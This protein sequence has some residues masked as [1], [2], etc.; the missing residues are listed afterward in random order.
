[1]KHLDDGRLQS[2][3]DRDRS[4]IT[5]QEAMEVEDHVAGCRACAARLAELEETSE[6]AR[7]LLAVAAP[8]REP[9][10]DFDDVV[11]RSRRG[12]P[13]GTGGR[14]W[15]AAGW[16]ASLV[17]ALGLGWLSN[18]LLGPGTD[19]RAPAAADGEGAVAAVELPPLLAER[20]GVPATEDPDALAR[21]GEPAATVLARAE[22]EPLRAE[23]TPP[24]AADPD[25]D[26]TIAPTTFEAALAA[27]PPA[28]Q[29]EPLRVHGRVRGPDGRPLAAVQ[30]HVPGAGVGTL[31]GDDGTF[32]LLLPGDAVATDSPG[33]RALTARLIGFRSSTLE[34]DPHARDS[35]TVDFRL[36]PTALALDELVVAAAPRPPAARAALAEVEGAREVWVPVTRDRAQ[37][38]AGFAPL[39]VPDL[40]VLE[41]EVGEVE[42]QVAVRVRQALD[43]GAA[44]TLVQLRAEGPAVAPTLPAGQPVATVR[45]GDVRVTGSAPIPADS[46]RALLALVP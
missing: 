5:E 43:S 32:S 13:R 40:P 25:P 18:D 14:W 21:E 30:V 7:S 26:I 22:E 19:A 46:L 45:R 33:S 42:G 27:T 34:I 4:G 3:L 9:V 1:M 2:W 11:R 10:P 24:A 17:A 31:T 35:V 16:A 41:I 28:E 23:A 36:E 38:A 12:G 8:G 37:S 15:M 39:A 44:L 20:A 6:Q 29:P